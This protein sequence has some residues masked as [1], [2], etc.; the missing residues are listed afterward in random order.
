M[1]K[2]HEVVHA[3]GDLSALRR[4]GRS[5]EFVPQMMGATTR[6]SHD[7]IE[8]RKVPDEQLLGGLG[9][10]VTS[11]IR[12]WL[13]AAGLIKWI[14]DIYLK[15]LQKLQSG[16]A[17]FRIEK[18]DITGDHQSNLHGRFLTSTD[19][20]ELSSPTCQLALAVLLCGSK[21]R[22]ISRL[23]LRRAFGTPVCRRADE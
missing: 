8:R 20:K 15:L 23:R 12:H 4:I 16:D 22:D 7:V 5:G 6:R 10:L 13:G 21:C 9:L 19:A 14:H 11:A 1:Q 18:V 17:D 2:F 3:G